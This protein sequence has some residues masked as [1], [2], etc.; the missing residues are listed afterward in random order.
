M[1]AGRFSSFEQWLRSLESYRS[2]PDFAHV[3]LA[4]SAPVMDDAADTSVCED[5]LPVSPER[6]FQASWAPSRLASSSTAAT[7][8]ICLLPGPWTSTLARG[9][10]QGLSF[11]TDASGC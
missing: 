5:W 2:G 3:E 9:A 10:L 1:K 11:G 8:R 6:T 4:D 7:W